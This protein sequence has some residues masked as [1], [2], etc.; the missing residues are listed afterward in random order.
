MTTPTVSFATC[1]SCDVHKNDSSGRFRV[2][3]SVFK[4]FGGAS[5]FCGP[6]VT[7]KCFEDNSLVKAAVDSCG[8]LETSAGRVPA[9]LVVDGGVY[10]AATWVPRP[11]KTAGPVC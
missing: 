2:L 9:V 7:I 10:W 11:S 3:P 5:K 4:S 8:L 6:V 1:D